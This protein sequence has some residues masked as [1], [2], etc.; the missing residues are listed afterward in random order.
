MPLKRFCNVA[1]N[2]RYR[3]P[4]RMRLGAEPVDTIADGRPPTLELLE[5]AS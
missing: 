4:A 3:G 1:R 5:I 2:D